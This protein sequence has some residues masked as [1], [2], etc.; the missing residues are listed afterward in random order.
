MLESTESKKFFSLAEKFDIF[1][2]NGEDGENY[3]T[4][5][6]NL[7]KDGYSCIPIMDK[8][9]TPLAIFSIKE[10]DKGR[11]IKKVSVSADVFSD[12]ISSDPTENKMFLEWM[13]TTFSRFIKS[14]DEKSIQKAVMFVTEDLPQAKTYLELFET[15]KRK[16]KFKELCASS[17]GLR[18]I[19]DPTNINQYKSLSQVFDAV[20]PF[21]EREPS[22]VEGIMEKFVLAGQAEIPFKD[23][24]FTVY[25]PKTTEASIIFEKFANWCTAQKD[26]GMF[27]KYTRDNRKPNGKL[28]DIYIVINNKFFE[29]ETNE[30]YQI[31]FETNQ[32]KNRKNESNVSIYEDVI[33][34]S[35][36]IAQYFQSELLPMAKEF[37]G[38]IKNNVYLNFLVKFGFTDSFFELY[39]EDIPSIK[40]ID[41]EIPR[42]P[43]IEKFQNLDQ[44]IMIN[45]KLRD[46][47]PSIGK[48][49]NLE[50]LVFRDNNIK[51]LPKEICELKNVQYIN[52]I[53]NPIDSIPDEISS[54]D[55]SNGGSLHRL[56]IKKKDIG[57]ENFKKLKKLLPQTIIE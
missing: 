8:D 12:M 21:V 54:L 27:K 22:A 4:K 38:D 11:Q 9:E 14:G 20:D 33:E 30:I 37:K 10:N 36:A 7:E 18:D 39:A 40:I 43:N 13:L 1:E 44:L 31:H 35:E 56:S 45:T 51:T 2:P 5:I 57:N 47:H 32:I 29:G 23:R 49:K 42:L 55:K 16:K 19:Q 34:K 26:N 41:E 15:H 48:L 52:L 3:E 6:F 24:K 46:I 53:G 17:D 28:S 50:L 25:V